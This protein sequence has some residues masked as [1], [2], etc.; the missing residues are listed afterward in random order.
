VLQS[1]KVLVLTQV[2]RQLTAPLK[3]ALLRAA[4]RAADPEL[5]AAVE[6]V[7]CVETTTCT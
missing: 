6:A 5:R 2:R 1:E 4:A 7:C 3:A